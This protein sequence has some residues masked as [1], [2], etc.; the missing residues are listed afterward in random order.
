MEPR[1]VKDRVIQIQAEKKDKAVAF[2]NK[3]YKTVDSNKPLPKVF[4][5]LLG[6]ARN[7][8]AKVY[9]T[10]NNRIGVP[11]MEYID[12]S[13]DRFRT[14][15]DP[16]TSTRGGQK[17]P[18]VWLNMED[19]NNSTE[20]KKRYAADGPVISSYLNQFSDAVFGSDPSKKGILLIRQNSYIQTYTPKENDP[21]VT[22]TTEKPLKNDVIISPVWY[23]DENA[24]AY[25]QLKSPFGLGTSA[26]TQKFGGKRKRKTRKYRK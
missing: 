11:V 22:V 4:Y 10:T 1:V 2:L 17:E 19:A 23:R 8:M 15:L 26:L 7:G 21:S 3:H 12:N 6:N 13:G 25:S 9:F 14:V 24:S 18:H 16:Y 5:I 20:M